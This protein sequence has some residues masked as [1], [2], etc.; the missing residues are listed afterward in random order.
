MKEC[1]ESLHLP[2]ETLATAFIYFHG[3]RKHDKSLD[4]YMLILSCLCLSSKQTEVPRKLRDFIN[5][6]Y[7]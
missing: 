4:V 1:A 6:G 7:R 5:V 3:Y 2:Q